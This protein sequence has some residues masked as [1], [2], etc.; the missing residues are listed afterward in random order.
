MSNTFNV[1]VRA[2]NAETNLKR[3]AFGLLRVIFISVVCR[4]QNVGTF[5]NTN[6]CRKARVSVRNAASATPDLCI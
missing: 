1:L 3:P 2:E 5:D 4:F 6:S